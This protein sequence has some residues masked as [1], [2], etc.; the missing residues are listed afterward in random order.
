MP[1]ILQLVRGEAKRTL[2]DDRHEAKAGT[3]VHMPARLRHGIRAH[4]TLYGLVRTG[5]IVL[6]RGEEKLCRLKKNEQGR[7]YLKEYE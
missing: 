5:K 6:P 4:P 1:A 2:G 3:R 7:Y